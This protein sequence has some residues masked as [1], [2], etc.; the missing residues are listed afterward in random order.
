MK[1]PVSEEKPKEPNPTSANAVISSSPDSDSGEN[2]LED[3]Q[4]KDNSSSTPTNGQSNE[5]VP[6]NVTPTKKGF[7]SKLLVIYKKVD[8]Y[9][10]IFILLLVVASIIAY[11]SIQK[12]QNAKIPNISSQSLDQ[13]ALKQLSGN[14]TQVGGTNQ[15]LNIQ[16]STVFS[17]NV[18]AKGNLQ[19]AGTLKIAGALVLPGITVTGISSLGQINADT[20][21]LTGSETVKG[22]LT[23][24]Q[25]LTVN[26]ISSFGGAINAP[27]I[28][29][30]TLAVN[31]DITFSHHIYANGSIPRVAS[32]SAIGSG[33]TV[34]LSGSDNAGNV[35]INTGS[36]ASAG[37]L[38]NIT[39]SQNYTVTPYI[40]ITPV[41]QA[42]GNNIG[43][44]ITRST[45][46]FSICANAPPSNAA[47]S[48]DY[49]VIG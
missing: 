27:S 12:N 8:I 34:S 47:M 22:Q 1:P 38:A 48:F 5:T 31:G 20:L 29:V 6:E 40:Q 21:T 25:G 19:V 37:C 49:T 44:Y 33:G 4:S 15:T 41:G 17:N 35:N 45:S 26:G 7:L 2:S 28:S 32:V 13:G 30:S 24:N 43:Y 18:L 36:G 14:D 3:A 23:A 39:F 42:A 9:F 10:L 46:G 11:I 16:S